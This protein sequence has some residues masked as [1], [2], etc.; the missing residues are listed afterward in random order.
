MT[1]ALFI[2][3]V[4]VLVLTGSGCMGMVRRSHI[5]ANEPPRREFD[6][7]LTRDL[8]AYFSRAS[9]GEV[10]VEWELLRRGATQFG[11]GYPTYYAWVSI[12]DGE[13]RIGQGAVWVAAIEQTRFDV[14]DY[15]SAEVIRA[16]PER[17][18][19]SFP[20]DVRIKAMDRAGV[21]EN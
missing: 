10:R 2:S 6:A 7:M 18:Q 1:R 13:A 8:T 16:T 17:L 15:V 21:L 20:A 11:V 14:R 12:Y 3:L 4:A 19:R 5:S 9:G